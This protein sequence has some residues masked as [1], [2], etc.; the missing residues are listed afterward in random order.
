MRLLDSDE[1]SNELSLLFDQDLNRPTR[2]GPGGNVDMSH[3]SGPSEHS[4]HSSQQFH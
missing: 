4:H 2:N 1:D 3:N